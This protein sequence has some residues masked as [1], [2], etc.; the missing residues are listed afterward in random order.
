MADNR[1]ISFGSG[2][3]YNESIQVRGDFVQGNKLVSQDLNQAAADI[4]QLLHQ[5][6]GRYSPEEAQQK[7]ADELVS[8]ARKDP[9][10]QKTLVKLGRYIA[11]NG[12]IEAGIGKIIELALKLLGI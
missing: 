5:L 3:T 2:G 1:N 10:A 9:E 8:Q 11:A 4:G 6:Q 12:G 7:A